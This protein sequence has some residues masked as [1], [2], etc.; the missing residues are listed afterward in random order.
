MKKQLFA[1]MI[2]IFMVSNK[3]FSESLL[4]LNFGTGY[5]NNNFEYNGLKHNI[6]YV[7][8]FIG[9]TYTFYPSYRSIFGFSTYINI[10]PD[11]SIG[12]NI[13]GKSNVPYYHYT[14][15]KEEKNSKLQSSGAHT[16][17]TFNTG[18]ALNLRL[19]VTTIYKS[20]TYMQFGGVFQRSTWNMNMV[21]NMDAPVHLYLSYQKKISCAQNSF[22]LFA[23]IGQNYGM[24]EVSVQFVYD[25]FSKSELTDNRYI[26]PKSFSIIFSCRPLTWRIERQKD[27][28]SIQKILEKEDVYSK[29][30][31]LYDE[32]RA[33]VGDI[34]FFVET[35][36]NSED[37]FDDSILDIPIITEYYRRWWHPY[38]I[39]E[40]WYEFSVPFIRT[41]RFTKHKLSNGIPGTDEYLE[42]SADVVSLPFYT[43]IEKQKAFEAIVEE[44]KCLQQHENRVLRNIFIAENTRENQRKNEEERYK[45]L[46]NDAIASKNIDTIAE[47]IKENRYSGYFYDD[48]YNEIARL[49]TKNNNIKLQELLSIS[50][51]YNLEK[52]CIY[53]DKHLSVQQWTGNGTFLAKTGTGDLVY[54][55]NVYDLSAVKSSGQNA[56]LKY[57]G[58]YEYSSVGAG[59]QVVA[60][61]DLIYSF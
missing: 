27:E 36:L 26:R 42:Y 3:A 13:S 58:T 43:E 20:F 2:L 11:V 57:I 5:R 37:K 39:F 30:Y 9:G 60:K 32:Q 10:G 54:I 53:L 21:K 19:P 50:N 18:L 34:P 23:E 17:Y 31:R 35:I 7:P 14:T 38:L 40:D 41:I 6:N 61:F 45:T 55:R 29:K 25:L 4:G 12:S 48:A 52:N 24:G 44:Y 47:Y 49:L 56:Y 22:S 16:R 33:K 1:I 15:Q 46:Y 8:L 59:L 28:T 51:P